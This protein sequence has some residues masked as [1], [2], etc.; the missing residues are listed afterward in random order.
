MCMIDTLINIEIKKLRL[1]KLVFTKEVVFKCGENILALKPLFGE[2][3]LIQD[4]SNWKMKIPIYSLAH[5]RIA[6]FLD[7]S[8]I[9]LDPSIF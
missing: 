4:A 2:L 9:K 1:L 6:I 7:Q 8:L 3:I 5:K